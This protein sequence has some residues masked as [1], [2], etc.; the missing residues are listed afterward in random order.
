MSDATYRQ[1]CSKVLLEPLENAL[2]KEQTPKGTI[3]H[4]NSKYFVFD[5]RPYFPRL[6]KEMLKHLPKYK[7]A[8]SAIDRL[9]TITTDDCDDIKLTGKLN[10]ALKDAKGAINYSVDDNIWQAIDF[11]CN[12]LQHSG[13]YSINAYH[14]DDGKIMF[15]IKS[16]LK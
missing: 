9:G 6:R 4:T 3:N 12:E 15:D 7:Q 8:F 13:R 2:G 5:I 10:K 14:F 1:V 16:F 11:M